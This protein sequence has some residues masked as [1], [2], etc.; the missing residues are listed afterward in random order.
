GRQADH[1]RRAGGARAG[2]LHLV[3]ELPGGRARRAALGRPPG[4]QARTRR[5]ARA[6]RAPPL[7][8]GRSVV[9]RR[10][11]GGNVAVRQARP[12]RPRAA[13]SADRRAG[14]AH[15]GQR[16]RRAAGAGEGRPR[17]RRDSRLAGALLAQARPRAAAGDRGARG[18]RHR[19]L[20]GACRGRVVR[21]GAGAGAVT[22]V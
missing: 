13:R 11:R 10:R 8:R 16:R 18:R 12:A 7:R 21:G 3:C 6:P 22:R 15:R 1:G 19:L 9:G 2:V 5:A 4:R 20:H 17:R 14:R